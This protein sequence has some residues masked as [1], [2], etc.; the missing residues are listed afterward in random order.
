M[1]R[2]LKKQRF[3]GKH[4]AELS[5]GYQSGRELRDK[6]PLPKAEPVRVSHWVVSVREPGKP[7][8]YLSAKGT[9]PA[10]AKAQRF[11]Q[12]EAELLVADNRAAH[13]ECAFKVVRPLA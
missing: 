8:A 11:E 10:V 2:G 7:V 13:P 1:R 9:T 6:Q 5:T 3:Y 12:E 4:K